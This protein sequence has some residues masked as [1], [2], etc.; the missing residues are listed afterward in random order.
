MQGTNWEKHI[1]GNWEINKFGTN[2][3]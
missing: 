1:W 2:G 3:E